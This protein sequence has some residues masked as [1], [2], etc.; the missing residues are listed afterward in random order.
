MLKILPVIAYCCFTFFLQVIPV[1]AYQWP[2]EGFNVQHR[3]VG[4]LGEPRGGGSRFH[5]GVDIKDTSTVEGTPVYTVQSGTVSH[6]GSGQNLYVRIGAIYYIHVKDR[7]AVGSSV[8]TGDY[9]CKVG[10]Y[11][12]SSPHLHFQ[13][14]TNGSS[15]S[16][17]P[18]HSSNL[19]PFSEL[20]APSITT[21][22]FRRHNGS[23]ISS[24][25]LKGNVDI[26]AHVVDKIV[27]SDSPRLG[28]YSIWYKGF[29]SSGSQTGRL[30]RLSEEVQREKDLLCS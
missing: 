10:P 20:T 15:N 17:N 29:Y 22:T 12:A 3:I 14:G 24:N 8:A 2:I 4:T 30:L 9:I 28:I 5:A 16:D 6:G 26:V 27:S 18:L 11:S 21:V 1:Y 13:V 25:A 23:A 7:V 19:T